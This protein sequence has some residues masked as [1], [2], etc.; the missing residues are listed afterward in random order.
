M[1]V[2][3]VFKLLL[4]FYNGIQK[5]AFALFSCEFDKVAN[6]AFFVCKII[7]YFKNCGRVRRLANIMS[8]RVLDPSDGD[9]DDG[10]DEVR[11]RP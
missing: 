7:C 9:D 10:K 2:I 1:T 8:V 11:T 5:K 3:N 6:H 4:S